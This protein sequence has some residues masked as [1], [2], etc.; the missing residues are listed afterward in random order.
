MTGAIVTACWYGSEIDIFPL[1]TRLARHCNSAAAS[2]HHHATHCC[3]EHAHL[4]PQPSLCLSNGFGF[5][6]I[7]SS[8]LHKNLPVELPKRKAEAAR[9][10][11]RGPLPK[12]LHGISHVLLPCVVFYLRERT[13]IVTSIV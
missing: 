1:L 13:M 8:P 7:S 11:F 9:V 3:V 5:P 2:H 4:S 6:A 10:L 12:D